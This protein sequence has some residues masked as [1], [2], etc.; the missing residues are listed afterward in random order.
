MMKRT[1]T[2]VHPLQFD[3]LWRESIKFGGATSVGQRHPHRFPRVASD[4]LAVLGGSLSWIYV[5]R[6]QGRPK[7]AKHGW[8]AEQR[9]KQQGMGYQ[10]RLDAWKSAVKGV[11]PR[12]CGMDDHGLI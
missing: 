3:D 9:G 4:L 11:L 7:I 8:L 6:L 5:A 1:H 2:C 12:Y 10:P